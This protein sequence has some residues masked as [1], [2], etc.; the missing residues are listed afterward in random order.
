MRSGSAVF[1]SFSMVFFS[2]TVLPSS[3]V[4][5]IYIMTRPQSF[6]KE[7]HSNIT[8][9]CVTHH[10]GGTVVTWSKDSQVLSAD[11]V[12]V[13]M[14]HRLTVH[15]QPRHGVNISIS[16]LRGSDSG[17]YR[18]TLNFNKKALHVEHKLLVE[19][20]PS[21]HVLQPAHKIVVKAGSVVELECRAS[22]HP[23]P[24]ITWHREHNQ[25][26]P[27]VSTPD[28][29]NTNAQILTIQGPELLLSNIQRSH[30]GDYICKAD[31]GV[32][33]GAV[34]ETVKLDVLFAPE[35]FVEN[36]WVHAGE[37]H[38]AVIICRV[39]ANPAP[40]VVWYRHTM[41]LID[42]SHLHMLNVGDTYKLVMGDIKTQNWGQY[43]CQ[44]SNSLGETSGSI[45]LTGAPGVPVVMPGESSAHSYSYHLAWKVVSSYLPLIHEVIYWENKKGIDETLQNITVTDIKATPPRESTKLQVHSDDTSV[46]Y[47]LNGLQPNTYYQ[48]GVKSYNK[49]GWSQMSKI[50]SFKTEAEADIPAPVAKIEV[51]NDSI[52]SSSGS[53]D[54]LKYNGP[55][56]LQ[57]Q[58]EVSKSCDMFS[59][60]QMYLFLFTVIQ[61]FYCFYLRC[62]YFSS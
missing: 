2:I 58:P 45:T 52:S 34:R 3:N 57:L 13:L 48:V 25:P 56:P 41:K 8:L 6:V 36:D 27:G 46:S 60:N 22:G 38:S 37:Q 12:K 33:H 49:W 50:H 62:F 47:S 40:K 9:P 32:G 44:A 30:S 29:D 26:F 43:H 51:D 59:I 31:N 42:S 15:H 35:V 24:H 16:N 28:D 39:L 5:E 20:A 21:I 11:N 14:D 18:C 53:G 1:V 7:L 23:P 54:G 55:D 61:S 19:V 17:H 10:T 4:E